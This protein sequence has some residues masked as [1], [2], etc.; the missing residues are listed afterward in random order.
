MTPIS[1]VDANP[2]RRVPPRRR[3]RLAA[4]VYVLPIVAAPPAVAQSVNR[5]TAEQDSSVTPSATAPLG[6]GSSVLTRDA[7]GRLIVRATR[8][9][10]P[11]TVDGQLDEVAYRNVPAIT[12]FVQQ[13][14]IQGEPVTERTE[15]WV[16]FDDTNLYIACRCWDTNPERIVAND[17]RRDSSSIS[18]QDGFTVALDTFNDQRDGFMFT[19]T[20][21]GAMRDGT[22][23][24][25]ANF[26]WNTVWDGKATRSDRG[27]VTEMAIPFKSLRYRPGREQTWSIQLRRAIVGKNEAAYLTPVSPAWSRRAIYRYTEAATLVGLEAPATRNL[28]IKPYAMSTV[29][30]DLQS[31]PA[32][33]NDFDPDGGIDVKYG[34]T[35]SLTADFTYNTDFAQ[36]EVDEAQV[37]LTRFSLVFPEKRDFFLEGQANF[38]FGTGGTGSIGGRD[39][40]TIFFSRHIGLSGGQ[41]IPVIAGGR[42]SGKAGAWNVGALNIETDDDATAGVAQ[43]NF[44]VLR[45]RRDVLRRS[46]IGGII[47]RRSVSTVAPGANDV[48]GLDAN[49]AFYQDVYLS[50]YLAKSRTEGQHGDDLSYRTQFNYTGD[51]YGLG[52][53]RLVVE[54]EFNPEVGFLRRKDFRRNFAQGRFSPRT[55]NNPIVRQFTW[56]TTFEYVTDNENRLE[57]RELTGMFRTDFHNSDSLTVQYS[58]LYEFLAAPFEISEGVRIPVGGYGFDNV[59]VA[60]SGGSQ[61][62][63]SGSAAGEIGNFYD[64]EKKTATFRGRIEITTQLGIEPNVSLNWVDLPE[65]RFTTTVAGARSVF[66]VTPRMFVA[67]LVQYS[68]SS[69]SLS[70][71]LR[72]RWEYEPG[73]DLFVVYTEGRSTLPERGTELQNRGII[74]KINRLFRF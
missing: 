70:T 72:F 59:R 47:T 23:A 49:F 41:A 56:Q 53:D 68:S 58:R 14:P 37:N 3:W 32:L 65:G 60:F 73:S 17:M 24:E 43:T 29:T 63:V 54:K 20:P 4:L 15:A 5:T 10:Q 64:G 31:S 13:V 74:V 71:N 11:I 38:T 57:S 35:K 33:R 48:F 6:T 46:T 66:T 69:T 42:L 9:T 21:A 36:V 18:N 16:L 45:L 62:R 61:R 67:A 39:V 40:P 19:V 30:T 34:L 8:I 44:T 25:R 55:R 22:T 51:R 1:H 28:E 7:N 2:T 12:E 50:G 27:W 52:L 26:N